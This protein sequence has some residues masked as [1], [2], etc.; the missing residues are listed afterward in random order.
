MKALTYLKNPWVLLAI[1]VIVLAVVW[2]LKGPLFN[3]N[4]PQDLP[5]EPDLSTSERQA[6]RELSMRLHADM[7]GINVFSSL[8]DREAWAQLMGMSDRM[9]VAVSNDF[10]KLYYREGEGT[11]RQWLSDE[12]WWADTAGIAGKNQVLERMASLNIQ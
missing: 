6:V 10:N 3:I 12:A 11:M 4:V 9:F 7:K 8:R 1:A 5:D 2:K